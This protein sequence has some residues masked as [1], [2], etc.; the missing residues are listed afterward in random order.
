MLKA[1]L[2]LAYERVPEFHR[3]RFRTLNKFGNETYSNF[4]FRLSLPF[5]SWMDGEEASTDIARLKEV[6]KLEQ[7][8]N[9]LPTEIHRWVV[10]KRPKL[11]STR[12]SW[13]TSTPFSTNHFMPNK[14]ILGNPTIEILR[15]KPTRP[16]TRMGVV[17]HS[18]KTIIKKGITKQRSL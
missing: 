18:I 9:C 1:A 5:N 8:T 16:F 2:L 14:I 15:I 10:E 12:Q 6:M 3:K 4:A 7:F 17:E 13:R 11:W